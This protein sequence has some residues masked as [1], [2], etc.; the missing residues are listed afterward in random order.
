MGD[1]PG[2]LTAKL[3]EGDDLPV[4]NV[5]FAEAEEFCRKLTE[6]G[7]RIRR[8]CRRSGS[9][10]CP[11]RRS[12]NTPAE[13]EQRRPPRSATQL[14]SKQANFHGQ[15]VQRG[16][17]RAVAG[18]R[19]QGRQLP[20]QSRGD[21]TTCTAMPSSGAETGTIRSCPAASIPICTWKVSPSRVRRGGGWT[22]DGWACRSAF[23]LRFEPE[24]RYDHI[25]FRV[26]VVRP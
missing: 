13:R 1:L 4:G 24:R 14:S 7:T 23:R 19:R 12:G 18:P 25:G 17:G 3:P 9:F 21:C 16:R 20:G 26:A 10:V 5:N 6:R 15:A 2:E 22:D 11:P 8:T